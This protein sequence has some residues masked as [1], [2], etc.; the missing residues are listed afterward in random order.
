MHC[1]FV[2]LNGIPIALVARGICRPLMGDRPSLSTES[3]TCR[4]HA[5]TYSRSGVCVCIA[6]SA[7]VQVYRIVILGVIPSHGIDRGGKC[8]KE[9][10][11]IAKRRHD[12]ASSTWEH[13]LRQVITVSFCRVGATR[14]LLLSRI[15][16]R[17]RCFCYSGKDACSIGCVV[18]LRTCRA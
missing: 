15:V 4:E 14:C 8:A 10:T 6:E 7:V 17:G 1:R 5:T 16:G 11:G 13:P 2:Q 12:A 9:R 3:V 18:E